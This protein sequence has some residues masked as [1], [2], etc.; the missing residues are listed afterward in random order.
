V[1]HSHSDLV[2]LGS[3]LLRSRNACQYAPRPSATGWQLAVDQAY[4]VQAEQVR[5]MTASGSTLA[6][7]KLGLTDQAQ[8]DRAGWFAPSFGS[9]TDTMLI[10]HGSELSLACGIRPRVEPEIVVT[11]A[12]EITVLPDSLGEFKS[13][14]RDVRLGIEVVDPRYDDSEFI[15]TDAL[16]D[17]SSALAGVLAETGVSAD[18]VD[19]VG[20]E[21]SLSINGATQ[22]AGA[23]SALKG[24]PLGIALDA[25]TERLRL[26]WAVP[27]GLSIFTGNVAG[28]AVTVQ[29]GDAVEVSSP[30]LQSLTLQVVV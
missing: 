7:I 2:A 20:E 23:G 6:A 8:Q 17:N 29:P 5:L 16:A 28:K 4:A 14:I 10:P 1:T 24:G 9:L 18:A 26:G 22:V 15:L 3:D 30:S 11:L 25:I 19:W 21:L 13:F 27:A 12:R